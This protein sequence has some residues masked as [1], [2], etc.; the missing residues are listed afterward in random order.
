MKIFKLKTFMKF[1]TAYIFRN[2]VPL[3]LFILTEIFFL[4][5][6]NPLCTIVHLLHNAANF[7]SQKKKNFM[8]L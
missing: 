8:N 3:L 4:G 6:P 2:A 1:L 5:Y 7:S